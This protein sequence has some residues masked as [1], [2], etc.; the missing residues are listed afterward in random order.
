MSRPYEIERFLV[1]I[2]REDEI[3][4]QSVHEL[5]AAACSHELFESADLL[6]Q[7][8]TAFRRANR[9]LERLIPFACRSDGTMSSE[10]VRRLV[11]HERADILLC[12]R[13]GCGKTLLATRVGLE[14]VESGGIAIWVVAWT[15]AA[16]ST[17]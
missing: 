3:N 13:S 5:I 10:E 9:C 16:T 1:A 14:F 7:Y 6:E 15:I 17:P 4:P 11:I 2:G 8:V 12:G